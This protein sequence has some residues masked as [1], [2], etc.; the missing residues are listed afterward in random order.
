MEGGPF[1]KW[2]SRIGA[3]HIRFKILH[4]L[5]GW[6]AVP[7]QN[8]VPALVPRTSSSK[9]A[10]I[11]RV[12]GGPFSKWGSR[13]GTAGISYT[14]RGRVVFKMGFS[15]CQ[16][17]LAPVRPMGRPSWRHLGLSLGRRGG[18]L[19]HH[20]A[21]LGVSRAMFGRSWGLGGPCRTVGQQNI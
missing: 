7:F 13:R 19:G 2:G 10:T 17:H 16:A 4:Q 9:F 18:V 1:S 12:E 14:D 5:H 6:R 11:T 8:G 20:G 3:A 21:I 15:Q